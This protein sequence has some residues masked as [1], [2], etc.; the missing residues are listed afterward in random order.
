MSLCVVFLF[1]CFFSV[2]FLVFVV[3]YFSFCG[4]SLLSH[5]QDCILCTPSRFF[6]VCS[7]CVVSICGV[8]A[9]SI[10]SMFFLH[11]L[12]ALLF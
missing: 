12:R 2:G 3:L 9:L 7:F 8:V 5:L 11:K 10:S 4:R 6:L 1:V